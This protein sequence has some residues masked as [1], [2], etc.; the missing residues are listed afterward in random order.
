MSL[1]G[2]ALPGS[3]PVLSIPRHVP[4]ELVV[5]A[6]ALAARPAVVLRSGGFLGNYGYDTSV[7]Y[8]AADALIHGRMPYRDFVLLHPPGLMLAVT[9]FALLGRLTTDHIGYAGANLGFS[10]VGALTAVLVVRVVKT[11]GLGARG[12]AVGGLFYAAWFTSV[13]A[14]FLARLEPLGN[15]LL[16]AGL[17]AVILARA[18][19]G[20]PLFALAGAALGLAM[21][22][23]IWFV[24]PL[25]VVAAWLVIVERRLPVIGAF[26]AGAIAA[27][28]VIDGPFLLLAPAHMWSMVISDQLGRARM[29]LPLLD[30]LAQVSSSPSAARHLGTGGQLALVVASGLVL[31]AVLVL[32]WRTN[33]ARVMV[34]LVLVQLAVLIASPSYFGFYGDYVAVALAVTVAAAAVT[35]TGRA[36]WIGWLPAVAAGV[37]T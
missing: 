37:V 3:A 11:L 2:A 22:V 14:E 9:P 5:L 32:A 13:S 23:K 15:L 19:R 16:A 7:Y 29:K 21:S 26:L 10:V 8:A 27:C 1:G 33:A 18:R 25:V 20:W 31:V 36:R 4:V 12:A 17:Y 6:F 24:V 30:R 34:V 28:L 35:L